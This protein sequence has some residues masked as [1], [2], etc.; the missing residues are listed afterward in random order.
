MRKKTLLLL[1]WLLLPNGAGGAG[2]H[3]GGE[4]E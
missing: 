2:E 3:V 4:H 1:M